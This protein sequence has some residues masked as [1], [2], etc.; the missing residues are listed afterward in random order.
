MRQGPAGQIYLT[1]IR[2]PN[3]NKLVGVYRPP[4]CEHEEEGRSLRGA[5]PSISRS[6]AG[7]G[8]TPRRL[9]APHSFPT[10]SSAAG[11]AR[12]SRPRGNRRRRARPAR[13]PQP[14]TPRG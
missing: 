5:L 11:L 3:G 13:R 6:A 1:Y 7:S 9:P 10:S 8:A 4:A 2:D 12:R 14:G